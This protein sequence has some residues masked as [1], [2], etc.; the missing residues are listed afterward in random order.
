[1]VLWER[2]WTWIEAEIDLGLSTNGAGLKRKDMIQL[3]SKKSK[4]RVNS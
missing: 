2:H 4:P 1:M 3:L